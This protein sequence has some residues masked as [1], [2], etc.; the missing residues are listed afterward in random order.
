MCL[1]MQDGTSRNG[2]LIFTMVGVLTQ[3]EKR[4]TNEGGAISERATRP[5]RCPGCGGLTT[6]TPCR[7]CI[8]VEF[9]RNRMP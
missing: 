2:K 3:H 8:A 6:T 9:R 4:Y 7:F 1:V 5:L